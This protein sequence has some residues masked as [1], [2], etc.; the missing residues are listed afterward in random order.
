MNSIVWTH[1]AVFIHSPVDAPVGCLH[2]SVIVKSAAANTY[3]QALVRVPVFHSLFRWWVELGHMI[4]V[5]STFGRRATPF[6]TVAP[7]YYISPSSGWGFYSP[8]SSPTLVISAYSLEPPSWVGEGMSLWCW[9]AF[10][11]YLMMKITPCA[12]WGI[13]L[14]SLE[15]CLFFF[16]GVLYVLKL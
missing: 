16:N 14:S 13:Y 6:A 7:P 1:H 15:K 5:C 10:P 4:T 3:V 12:H 8:K 9:L 11:Y 2:L